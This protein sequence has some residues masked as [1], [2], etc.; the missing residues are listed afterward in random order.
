MRW[1]VIF[2]HLESNNIR[3]SMY[4][5]SSESQFEQ[6]VVSRN[7]SA[8]AANWKDLSTK[9]TYRGKPQG[10][11]E[12][13]RRKETPIELVDR[14][15]KEIK[16]WA[17]PIVVA[18]FDLLIFQER[19]KVLKLYIYEMTNHHRNQRLSYQSKR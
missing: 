10:L 11:V 16:V 7:R 15:N 9:V 8:D 17:P 5:F 19:K 13:T 3:V 4:S 18:L 6:Y 2:V 12:T 1:W 14:E